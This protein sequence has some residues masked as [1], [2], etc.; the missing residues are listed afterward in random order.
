M[1]AVRRFAVVVVATASMAGFGLATTTSADAAS[2]TVHA[3]K[4]LSCHGKKATIVGKGGT[5]RGTSKRDVIVLTRASKVFAGSGNDLICG[6]RGNDEIHGGRGKDRI[7]GNAGDD[8]IFGDDGD[9][10]LDG[11]AGDD[12]IET[13]S[14][15]DHSDGG[16]GSDDVDGVD[17]HGNHVEP[18]DDHGVHAPGTDDSGSHGSDHV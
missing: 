18:G 2:S 3:R 1:K 5:V 13:G 11:G 14:G 6:S 15:R 8:D 9:D 7:F 17:D 10:S 12:S 4:S 16:A